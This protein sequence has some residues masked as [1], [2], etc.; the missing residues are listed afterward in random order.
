MIS[1]SAGADDLGIAVLASAARTAMSASGGDGDAVGFFVRQLGIDARAR[2]HGGE[3]DATLVITA[4]S[5]G[6]EF[7]VTLQDRGLP[8]TG[9]PSSLL[10]LLDAGV[11]TSAEA[12]TDGLGN[13]T[14]VR[15]ALPTHHRIFDSAA[16]EILSED[17][18]L[19]TDEVTIR[20]MVPSDA[21]ALTR[22]IY[23]CYGWSYP[24]S[25][26]YFPDRIAAALESGQRIGE[27]AVTE[28]GEIAAHW[29]AVFLSPTVVETGGT[30]TD[31][32]FR[33]RGLAKALGD[34]LLERLQHMEVIGRVR[35]PV[36]TH[37]ATQEIALQEG[38][39]MVGAYL[40]ILHPV[41]Q[42]GITDG[43][44]AAKVS[45]SVA[46]SA[47]RPL[48]PATLWIPGP[49]EDI[50]R[51]VLSASDWPRE[52]GV[53]GHTYHCPE[54]SVLSTVYDS[55]NRLGMV[56]VALVGA[57]LIDV[58][59]G[60][61]QQMNR[62]GAE[63]VG[64]RLPANQP[65]LAVVAAGLVE[66]GLSYASLIPALRPPT[67]DNPGGDVLVTQWLVEPEF[68]TSGWVFATAGVEQLVQAVV[69]QAV[70]VGTRGLER[71]RRAARR[72]QLFASLGD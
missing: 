12:R 36:M 9:P 43:L 16:E 1:I 34:R 5:R 29:A 70:E 7:V 13:V 32:R 10:P 64:V 68:D 53:I 40:N 51:V 35:E 17:A 56:D 21:A 39:T 38:A 22:T 11:A 4:D 20:S 54:N 67:A 14:E 45:I 6:T 33:R 55:G 66:L 60:V 58:V 3:E 23:R 28:S 57:D 30:V 72:A 62:S 8:V 37:P 63:Y 26:L 24:I 25:D 19:R 71:Q 18:E 69:A 42:I 31:P 65:A 15:F 2:L 59:D 46:Y 48:A 41:Q 61:L 27:V 52:F 47:L 50:A 49:Y 44:L